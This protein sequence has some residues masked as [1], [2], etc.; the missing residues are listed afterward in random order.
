MPPSLVELTL[1]RFA[2]SCASPRRCSGCSLPGHHDLRARHRVPR[3]ARRAEP[4]IGVVE[5]AGAD[6]LAASRARTGRRLHGAPH[7]SRRGRLARC[8]TAARRWW[9]CPAPADLPVRS[10]ARREPVG[11]AGRRRGAAARGGTG[12]C[13]RAR[14]AADARRP[15][16]RYI[17]WLVPGLL[18]MNIMGTGLWGV[19]FSIVQRA[20]AQAAQAAGGDADV[21]GAL[22]DVARVQPAGVPRARVAVIVGFAW[23]FFGVE[24]HG[25]LVL[26]AGAVAARRAVVRRPRPAARQPRPHHRGGVGPDEPGDAADVGAVSGV[27]F[28][29]TNFPDAMQPFIQAAAVDG[30]ERR[31]CAPSGRRCRCRPRARRRSRSSRCASARGSGRRSIAPG[32][33]R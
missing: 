6:E 14:R 17:D 9:S 12:R 1:A 28:A 16:S 15:G 10:G 5:Q 26:L 11:A 19:G 22:P 18:G 2:S 8:A 27:F 31:G 23:L 30:A 13:V 20:H 24:V 4:V 33:G 32:C 25:A 21:E 7:R 29:S 3:T